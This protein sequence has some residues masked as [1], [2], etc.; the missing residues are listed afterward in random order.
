MSRRSVTTDDDDELQHCADAIFAAA[1][2]LA[3]EFETAARGV[4]LSKQQAVVLRTLDSPRAVGELAEQTGVD[5]SNLSSVLRRLDEAGLVRTAPDLSD[6]RA[7]IVR[8]TAAGTRSARRFE[9][10][11]RGSSVLGRLDARARADLRAALNPIVGGD[12]THRAGP[13][14]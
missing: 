9:D 2:A 10:A 13:M 11:L 12:R 8:R 4:G 5:P 14:A 6:R 3:R 7:R 1:A